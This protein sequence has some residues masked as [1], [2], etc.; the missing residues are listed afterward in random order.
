MAAA[1]SA[2]THKGYE[3]PP[4]SVEAAEGAMELRRYGAHLVAEVTV[5]G[6]REAAINTGFRML[7]G[8]IFGGNA[9]GESIAMTVP[10]AQSAVA[11]GTWTVRFM[12]PGGSDAATLPQPGDDRIRFVTVGPERQ[13]ALRFSGLRGTETLQ[14]RA[15]ELR[16]WTT[17]QGLTITTGPHFYFYDGPMTLPWMRRNEVA[18]TVQ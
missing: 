17:A 1:V 14:A 13:T 7:A 5:A 10:V 6:S 12:M 11:E 8:Y 16:A 4:Y 15:D 18:F 2:E 9:K 3:T